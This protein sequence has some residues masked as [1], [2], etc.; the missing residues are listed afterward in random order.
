M[1]ESY[2][3]LMKEIDLINNDILNGKEKQEEKEKMLEFK[4][5]EINFEIKRQ[6]YGIFL[7]SK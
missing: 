6:E 4:Y 2:L 5:L 7:K 3:S 1:E